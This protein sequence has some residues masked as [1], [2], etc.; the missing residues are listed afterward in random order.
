MPAEARSYSGSDSAADSGPQA[1]PGVVSVPGV[2]FAFA[3]TPL[4][5]AGDDLATACPFSLVG[6][7][8]RLQI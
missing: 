1:D 3:A 5:G 6:Q 8:L 2:H 7:H 4:R